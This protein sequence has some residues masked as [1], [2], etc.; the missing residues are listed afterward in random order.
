[1][2]Y[3]KDTHVKETVILPNRLDD[4]VKADA[5]KEIRSV[6][7]QLVYIVEQYYKGVK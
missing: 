2:A 1:M 5:T 7:A 4:L 6:S 3:N